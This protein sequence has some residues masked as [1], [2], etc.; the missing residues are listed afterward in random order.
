MSKFFEK[1]VRPTLFRMNAERAHELGIKALELGLVGARRLSDAE[2]ALVKEAYG[3]IRR[4][5]LE[6]ENPLG[7]AAGFDKNA[8]VVNR[9]AVLG[10]GFVEVGTVTYK[11][12]PGNS[13]PRLF[14]L[15][16]DRALINRL[17]FNNEG[18]KTVAERLS[19]INRR[20]V[21]GVNIGRNKD[22]GNDRAIEN[23]LETLETVHPV[24]DYIAV[25]VSSPN[26]PNLRQ[27]QAAENLGSLLGALQ[28][29]NNTLGEKP[30]LVKVAPDMDDAG[31]ESIVEVCIQKKVSGV[32]ATNTT[33]SREGLSTAHAEL[34]GDGGLSGWPLAKRSNAVIE[35]I[36]R[37][38]NGTLPIIGVGGV[39]TA[40]DAFEK[41][42]KGSSLIQAY[43][44][45]IYS[46]PSF[47]VDVALGLAQIIKEK[48]FSN[49][50]EAV[51]SS[52]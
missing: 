19:R 23:Y 48:G 33:T 17:G 1:I 8:V 37:S 35:R 14:R 9:L 25:N 36:Y 16:D 50:D 10:F 34:F 18:A 49:L 2:E 3:P 43:T 7:I 20:C 28:E 44:G 22:V 24:A 40:N 45:F 32:I 6:F 21:I 30:L 5:G 11:P 41:I 27:L 31:I 26:T 29:K 39:F 38:S 46:G 4:F 52:V 12:Q 15:P 13:K 47:P 51:G 42:S